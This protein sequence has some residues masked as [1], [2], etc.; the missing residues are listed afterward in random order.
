MQMKITN[1]TKLLDVKKADPTEC[2]KNFN[3]EL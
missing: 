1:F 2:H 3:N